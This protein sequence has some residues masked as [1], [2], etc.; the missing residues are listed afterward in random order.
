MQFRVQ[1]VDLY[2]GNFMEQIVEADNAVHAVVVFYG[3]D[4]VAEFAQKNMKMNSSGNVNEFVL[5]GEE[6]VLLIKQLL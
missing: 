6:Q 3:D 5:K 1:D 4:D 2:K